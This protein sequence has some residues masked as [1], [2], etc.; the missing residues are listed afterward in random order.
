MSFDCRE[1]RDE[2]LLDNFCKV[3]LENIKATSKL[4]NSLVNFCYV[5][6]KEEA[7]RWLFQIKSLL[8]L[9]Q[10]RLVSN[11]TIHLELL[12]RLTTYGVLKVDPRSGISE[13]YLK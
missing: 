7:R 12:L 2:E 9:C 5:Q 13:D 4:E 6:S 10:K 3:L 1:N 8:L 11:P